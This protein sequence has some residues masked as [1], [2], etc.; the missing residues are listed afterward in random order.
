MELPDDQSPDCYRDF[1][2]CFLIFVSVGVVFVVTTVLYYY[3]PF[4]TGLV[5]VIIYRFLQIVPTIY[6]FYYDLV[7]FKI[8]GTIDEDDPHCIGFACG[9]QALDV[10]LLFIG[11]TLSSFN[12]TNWSLI[13]HIFVWGQ[14][15]YWSMN[16][17]L[18]FVIHCLEN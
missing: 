14:I 3:F 7:Y 16:L 2:I 17:T 4:W 5:L 1:L 13:L 18:A 11:I 8:H 12:P 9:F 6:F 10:C 15:S